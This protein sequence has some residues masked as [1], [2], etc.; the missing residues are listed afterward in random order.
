MPPLDRRAARVMAR[1]RLHS[2][3]RSISLDLLG[4]WEPDELPDEMAAWVENA[5]ATAASAVCDRSLN[6][7]I[8]VLETAVTGAPP[9]VLLRL[10]DAAVR[11]DSGI[12]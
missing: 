12:D 4:P 3:L 10:D 2:E 7:L 8:Q 5:A 1:A 6:A 11:H 9:D